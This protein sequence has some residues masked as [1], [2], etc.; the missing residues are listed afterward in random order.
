MYNIHTW[1][2]AGS[3]SEWFIADNNA[4][5]NRKEIKME[6]TTQ[7]TSLWK[8]CSQWSPAPAPIL[9]V[10]VVSSSTLSCHRVSGGDENWSVGLLEVRGQDPLE[11]E[12]D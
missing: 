2:S 3:Y 5:E 9:R 11:M 8:H 4:T 6:K 7:P 12:E 10:F 1:V